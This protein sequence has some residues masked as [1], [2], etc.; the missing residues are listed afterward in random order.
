MNHDRRVLQELIY[1]R[2]RSS[3]NLCQL[4][5]FE[6]DLTTSVQRVHGARDHE[7]V[8]AAELA[9]QYIDEAWQRLEEWH[10]MRSACRRA[11]NGEH[12]Q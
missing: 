2:V 4:V 12:E 11:R 3:V 10:E 6:R 9:R 8:E 1:E 5:I 7:S